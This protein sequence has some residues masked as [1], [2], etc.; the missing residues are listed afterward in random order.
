MSPK[1]ASATLG[2]WMPADLKQEFEAICEARG[3]TASKQVR[4]WVEYTV[5]EERERAEAEGREPVFRAGKSP[6]GTRTPRTVRTT[7]PASKATGPERVRVKVTLEPDE[8]A[9]VMRD[10]ERLA[11]DRNAWIV[12]AVRSMLL[13]RPE[14]TPEEMVLLAT[15]AGEASRLNGHLHKVIPSPDP[16]TGAARMAVLDA[17]LLVAARLAAEQIRDAL[18]R[19]LAQARQRWLEP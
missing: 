9:A 8:L 6:F 5:A 19:V 11:M 15:V 10:C 14:L 3:T 13:K 17:N 1:H 16:D 7:A 12:R 2:S 18:A 4:A